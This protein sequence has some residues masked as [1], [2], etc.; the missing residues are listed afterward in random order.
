MKVAFA[1]TEHMSTKSLSLSLLWFLLCDCIAWLPDRLPS[2][3]SYSHWWLSLSCKLPEHLY[4]LPPH[5]AAYP[6][7]HPSGGSCC[8]PPSR[9][10][11]KSN[12]PKNKF[13]LFFPPSRWPYHQEMRS[14]VPAAGGGEAAADYGVNCKDQ[15]LTQLL[16]WLPTPRMDG[17]ECMLR[18][19]V[20]GI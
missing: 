13:E 7:V 17:A 4:G 6:W 12:P 3:L 2:R 14:L 8:H 20:L 1:K 18:C 16:I 9:H 19:W 10:N 5:P 15:E 11:R